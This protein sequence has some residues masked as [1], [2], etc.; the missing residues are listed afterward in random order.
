MA[1]PFSLFFRGLVR[2]FS[3]RV[4]VSLRHLSEVGVRRDGVLVGSGGGVASGAW[5]GRGGVGQ[6]AFVPPRHAAA[7]TGGAGWGCAGTGGVGGGQVC[8]PWLRG[9][10]GV[11]QGTTHHEMA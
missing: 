3:P 11:G 5:G 1:L 7:A 2:V 10:G 9:V 4:V 6:A 8:P